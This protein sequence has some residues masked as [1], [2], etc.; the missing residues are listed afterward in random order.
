MDISDDISSTS[1]NESVRPSVL[2]GVD[3]EEIFD[4]ATDYDSDSENETIDVIYDNS[5]QINENYANN[6]TVESIAN[7][8]EGTDRLNFFEPTRVI[9]PG[10]NL[11]T[12]TIKIDSQPNRLNKV[13]CTHSD[14]NSK[15]KTFLIDSI[16]GKNRG[17]DDGHSSEL[18]EHSSHEETTDEHNGR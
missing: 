17:G 8:F 1:E 15:S 4:C 7:Q 11:S 5:E 14:V 13:N 6:I 18:E 16:L 2:C 10:T 12:S 3:K 9:V